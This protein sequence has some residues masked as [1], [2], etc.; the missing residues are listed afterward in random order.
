MMPG[1]TELP[2][3][4]KPVKR[5]RRPGRLLKGMCFVL[6]CGL[7]VAVVVYSHL[8]TLQRVMVHGNNYLQAEEIEQI[9]HVYRGQPLFQLQTDEVTEHLLQDLRIESAVVRRELPDTLDISIVERK[10]IATIATNYGYADLD[11][12][13]MVIASYKSLRQVPL[14]LI[15][16]LKLRDK[17]VG[18]EVSDQQVMA[19]IQFLQLLDDNAL[20][21]LSEVNAARSDAITLYT[22]S[23]V[24]IRLGTLE[25]L[26]EKAKLTQD[27]L[28][29]LPNSKHDIAYVDFR[30]RAPY[31]HLNEVYKPEKKAN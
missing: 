11:R 22:N 21:Q 14:P 27:F 3:G 1:Q 13:G 24:Q 5:R 28:N 23:S 6:A 26:E 10:P 7:L 4:P 2:A 12:Q 16:G 17:F 20:N 18:D 29:A 30:Y 9:G 8:F 25:R 15:S 31:I 19:L